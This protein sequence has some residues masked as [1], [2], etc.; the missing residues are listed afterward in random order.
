MLQLILC[1]HIK[2]FNRISLT[3][4]MSEGL[5][6]IMSSFSSCFPCFSACFAGLPAVF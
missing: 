4:I 1:N 5:S 6:S 3:L 2:C